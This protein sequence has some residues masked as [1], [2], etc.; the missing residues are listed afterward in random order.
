MELH[1]MVFNL[2]TS[3]LFPYPF[4]IIYYFVHR[5]KSLFLL[6][7]TGFTHNKQFK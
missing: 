1:V 2:V 6:R 5:I 7:S 4:A 3:S